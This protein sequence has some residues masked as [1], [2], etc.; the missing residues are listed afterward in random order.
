MEI[1][2]LLRLK[3][4][5]YEQLDIETL[6]DLA[7]ATI[8]RNIPIRERVQIYCNVIKKFIFSKGWKNYWRVKFLQERGT[9]ENKT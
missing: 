9:I 8:D 6:P 3:N 4:T 1:N 2:K 7:D 5:M